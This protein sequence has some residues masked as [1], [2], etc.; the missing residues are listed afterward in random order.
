MSA[1]ANTLRPHWASG[2]HEISGIVV[3]GVASW[4]ADED[5]QIYSDVTAKHF[6]LNVGNTETYLRALAADINR[7]AI[8]SYESISQATRSRLFPRSNAW[9]LIKSYYSAFFAAH[10]ILKMLGKSFLNVDQ[11]QISSVNKIAK[12]YGVSREDVAGGNF[13]ATF[14]GTSREITWRRLDSMSGGVHER[15]WT[16]FK[17]QIDQLSKDVLKNNLGTTFDYQRVSAKLTELVDNLS[18]ESCSKGTWLSMIRNSVN[19]K[20][21]FGSWY[22]YASQS[23]MGTVDERLTGRWNDDPMTMNLSL[24][25][26]RHIRKFQE[27]CGFIV[28]C[29]R[30]LASDMAERCPSG[31]SFHTYGWLAI[32]RLAAQRT[33]SNGGR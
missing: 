17:E 7:T 14:S 24:H 22:P 28:A 2:L 29:C 4:L 19:Y 1:L 12:L 25:G 33:A 9:I 6:T 10:A 16:F 26:D 32:T 8:A 20:H 5:Y 31:R 18:S 13:I 21:Q 15:F 23:P 3:K 30:I 11:F 27:T